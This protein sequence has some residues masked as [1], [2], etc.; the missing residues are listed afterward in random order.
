MRTTTNQATH[1]SFADIPPEIIQCIINCV[2]DYRQFDSISQACTRLYLPARRAI[3][4]KLVISNHRCTA[5]NLDCLYDN[6]FSAK[7]CGQALFPG[8]TI[9]QITV[10]LEETSI[11]SQTSLPAIIQF[12]DRTIKALHKIARLR[13]H[14]QLS[15]QLSLSVE[16]HLLPFLSQLFTVS[17][18]TVTSYAVEFENACQRTSTSSAITSKIDKLLALKPGIPYTNI[19]LTR[20]PLYRMPASLTRIILSGHLRVF[21]IAACIWLGEGGSAYKQIV[22]G[23]SLQYYSIDIPA[24]ADPTALGPSFATVLNVLQKNETT[25]ER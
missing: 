2:P 9:R 13:I 19:V 21:D 15:S 25:L 6:L 17:A 3:Y 1:A 12:F 7:V 11:T 20:L 18:G 23:P 4:Q 24:S 8:Q 10:Q 5:V 14:F 16:S 22:P